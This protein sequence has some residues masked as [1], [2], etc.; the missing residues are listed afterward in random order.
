MGIENQPPAERDHYSDGCSLPLMGIENRITGAQRVI[1]YPHLITP[2]GDRK[3]DNLSW[4]FTRSNLITPHGDRKRFV[5]Q[6][7][8]S[9]PDALITP[10][11]DRKPANTILADSITKAAHYPS[12]G[13]KTIGRLQLPHGVAQ[14]ITPHGDR[15]R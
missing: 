14:L 5:R 7:L 1:E 8:Q 6:G 4:S 11:G 15:K 3:L 2:H 13:S 9:I 10:H 12:W